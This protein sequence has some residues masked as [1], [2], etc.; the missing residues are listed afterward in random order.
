MLRIDGVVEAA[1]VRGGEFACQIGEGGA[2]LRKPG[3]RGLADDG[4][5]IVRRKIVAGV[6]KGDAAGGGGQDA[7]GIFCY[8]I[9]VM[10]RDGCGGA[11]AGDT[12]SEDTTTRNRSQ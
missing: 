6:G 10:L 9:R 4:N 8:H 12:S 5:G 11:S 1:D 7:P 2:E 3:E